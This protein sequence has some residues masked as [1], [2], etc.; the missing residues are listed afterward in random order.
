MIL[1]IA[2]SCRVSTSRGHVLDRIGSHDGRLHSSPHPA[3]SRAPTYWTAYSRGQV[4]LVGHANRSLS[5]KIEQ[6]VRDSQF[7][8]MTI[9][10]KEHFLCDW[11]KM[12]NL[13]F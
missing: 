6:L 7:G 1:F 4:L 9:K 10:Q 12:L 8:L 13:Y 11:L 2:D 5:A 3:S